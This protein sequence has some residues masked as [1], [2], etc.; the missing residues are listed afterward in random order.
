MSND[1]KELL[2]QLRDGHREN[3]EGELPLPDKE[4]M[5]TFDVGDVHI[6]P[7]GYP[8]LT[9]RSKRKGLDLIIFLVF[10]CIIFFLVKHK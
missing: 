9:S 2:R 1:P 8:E 7:A 3:N 5:N 6:M 10:I 4:G